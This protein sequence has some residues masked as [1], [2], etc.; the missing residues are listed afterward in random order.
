MPDLVSNV[1]SKPVSD[2]KMEYHQTKGQWHVGE[3]VESQ[4][5]WWWQQVCQTNFK[6]QDNDISLA[7]T[8][9]MDNSL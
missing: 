5:Q 6:S 1:E 9:I 7:L 2:G 4:R 3:R 8:T